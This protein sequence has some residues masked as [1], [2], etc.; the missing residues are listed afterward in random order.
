MLIDRGQRVTIRSNK[1]ERNHP[2]MNEIN[3]KLP[4][5]L[6]SCAVF[7]DVDGTLIDI[8]E[9]PDQVIMPHHLPEQLAEV[10]LILNGALALISGRS[11]GSIDELFAPFRF[12]AAGLHGTEIRAQQD[13]EIDFERVDGAH[14]SSARQY[15]EPL[16]K[17]WPGLIV[18]D[19]GIAIAVHYRQAPEAASHVD[20]IV[21]GVLLELGSRWTRQDGKMVVEI[22]PSTSNK[23]AAIAK[24]MSAAPFKG[25]RPIAVGDD[26]T[27][28]T[29]FKF[30]NGISGRSIKV[31]ASPHVSVANF[32]VDSPANVRDWISRL[33]QTNRD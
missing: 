7:L 24:L 3:E 22:H 17:H 11:I 30:V 5:D 4:S 19:K 14:L 16:A 1:K 9:T 21:E 33:V 13:G 2:D 6:R 31:G 10:S 18:E 8:A 28:E 25:R 29:M 27:D 12:P 26:L 23:G 32:A 15:L 20:R